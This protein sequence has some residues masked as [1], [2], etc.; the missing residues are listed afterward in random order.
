MRYSLKTTLD[1]SDYIYFNEHTLKVYGIFKRQVLTLR[2][3]FLA[4]LLIVSIYEIMQFEDP[5][6][7]IIFSVITLIILIPIEIFTP[8]YLRFFT[9]L[10]IKSIIKKGKAPYSKTSELKFYDDY[11]TEETETM[12][13]EQKYSSIEK[14]SF[15]EERKTLYLHTNKF[16]ALLISSNSFGSPEEMVEFL[17]FIKEKCTEAECLF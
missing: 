8:H 17:K 1:D 13:T 7:A 11:F 2:I 6:A 12:T 3:L 14:I 4:V 9:R 16:M 5:L 15:S 10:Q